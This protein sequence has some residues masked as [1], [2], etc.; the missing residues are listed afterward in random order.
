MDSPIAKKSLGQHWLHDEATLFDITSYAELTKDDTVLEIGPGLGTLTAVLCKT[1]G[2]V[3]AIELDEKLAASLKVRV[4]DNNLETITGDILSFDFSNLPT[5]YK[6][7]ANIPY[8]LTSNLI[9]ILSESSNPPK[10]AVLLVQKEVAQRVAA[11]PGAMSILSV[12]SQIYWQV[13]LGDIVPAVMFMPPPKVDSQVLILQRYSEPLFAKV[14]Y[15]MLFRLVKVGFSQRRK[16]LLNNLTSGF[17]LSRETVTKICETAGIDPGRR[18]QT[19]SLTE[20]RD[21]YFAFQ[22]VS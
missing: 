11:G 8:Y 15:S 17:K 20:W 12:T 19:M 13:S 21:L 5:G 1:S 22:G 3:I 14:D 9:R 10:L 18:A 6:L 2:K 7:V 4:P 16:T